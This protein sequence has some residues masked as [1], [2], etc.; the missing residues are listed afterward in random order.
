MAKTQR[1]E[2]RN[3]I[4][5]LMDD[6]KRVNK[7]FEDFEDVDREDMEAVQELVETA[8]IELQI[9]SILEEEIFYP[10]MRAGVSDNDRE[11]DD[12]LNEAQVEHE[13]A[14][15]LIARI[16]ELDP[17]DA[18]YPA[19][20]TVLSEYVKH[21]VKEEE[22][23]LFA[24]ARE[25]GLDLQQLGEDM[26]LRRE[27]LFSEMEADELDPEAESLDDIEAS[28]DGEEESEDVLQDL[29]IPRTRH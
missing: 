22:T 5:L 8:C 24:K 26:R 10:A 1:A 3:A 14:D 7:L 21:H 25:M 28:G 9:H 13:S 29:D 27:E 4:D 19:Y 18:M 17:D 2:A 20:F 6:H 11:C 16:Q 23:G 15:E 12:L